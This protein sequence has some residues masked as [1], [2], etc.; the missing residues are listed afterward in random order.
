M[1]LPTLLAILRPS[2]GLARML[3]RLSKALEK[4]YGRVTQPAD[5][6]FG[7]CKL[8]SG[9]GQGMVTDSGPEAHA[10]QA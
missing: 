10:P 7:A 4:A 5:P 3:P 2:L 9:S 1:A 8:T 6:S